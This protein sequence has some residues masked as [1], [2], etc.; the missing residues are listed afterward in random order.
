MPAL[1]SETRP[2][3]PLSYM[4][5]R[6]DSDL[7]REE[8]ERLRVQNE[9]LAEERRKARE[10]AQEWTREVK[11]LESDEEREKAAKKAK[12]V[13]RDNLSGDE[14]ANA[15]GE[16]KGKKRR[17]KLSKKNTADSGDDEALFSGDEEEQKPRKVRYACIARCQYKA[18]I[19]FRG[20]YLISG[21]RSVRFVMT[22]TTKPQQQPPRGRSSS[23]STLSSPPNWPGS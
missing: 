9:L 19:G 17:G 3:F 20:V 1:F 15:G 16:P 10:Q 12:R 23:K 2:C 11:R 8:R 18:N 22:T 13:K 7:Q 14:G 21:Q 5:N 6:T 4:G